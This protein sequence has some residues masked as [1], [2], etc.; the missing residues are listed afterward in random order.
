MLWVNETSLPQDWQ[1]ERAWERLNRNSDQASVPHTVQHRLTACCG[2][3][4]SMASIVRELIAMETLKARN[5][6]SRNRP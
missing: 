3:V 5:R 4:L 6:F 2:D 1:L